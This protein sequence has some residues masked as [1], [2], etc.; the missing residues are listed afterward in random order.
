MEHEFLPHTFV[1]SHH[2]GKLLLV[3]NSPATI[4]IKENK[5]I[6]FQTI[7]LNLVHDFS[8]HLRCKH[9][10]KD[11][12]LDV[13]NVFELVHVFVPCLKWAMYRIV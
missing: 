13:L 4:V 10:G 6:F 2:T 3:N 5:G 12:A 7:I 11:S 9:C 8:Y 1:L